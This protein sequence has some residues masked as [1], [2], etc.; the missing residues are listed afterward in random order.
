MLAI[1][2]GNS[3][4]RLLDD[5]RTRRIR[6]PTGRSRARGAGLR[7]RRDLGFRSAAALG[8]VTSADPDGPTRAWRFAGSRRGLSHRLRGGRRR[9]RRTARRRRPP[10]RVFVRCGRSDARGGG[11]AGPGAFAVPDPARVPEGCGER[12]GGRREPRPRS[13]VTG[14][15]PARA[16]CGGLSASHHGERRHATGRGHP[17]AAVCSVD[18]D[19]GEAVL[20]CRHPLRTDRRGAVAEA[21]RRRRSQ[22]STVHEHEVRRAARADQGPTP[23]D[24]R[25]LGNP[26]P[27][28]LRIVPQA[29]SCASSSPNSES[30]TARLWKPA[31]G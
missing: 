27:F 20:G 15:A 10:R 16:H 17:G 6:R 25:S 23:R 4:A 2:R 8:R 13:R 1:G 5:G 21:R 24:D 7:R 3:G 31:E 30:T 9:H 29:V 18:V 28:P 11:T 14:G 22:S 12:T 26:S 19:A